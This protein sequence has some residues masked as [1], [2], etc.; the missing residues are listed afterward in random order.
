MLNIG[1][2]NKSPDIFN[3]AISKWKRLL[4]AYIYLQSD[5]PVPVNS[6]WC[7]KPAS[8]RWNNPMS[9]IDGLSQ[10]SCRDFE[11]TAYGVAAL[12]N[13]AETASIQGID[14]YN[15]KETKAAERLQK[16][17][18]LHAKYQNNDSGLPQLCKGY[19]GIKLNTI[20]TF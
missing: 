17:M 16:T 12:I 5:G 6:P 11:H 20:G 18:E 13:V 10:E 3:D 9:F 19:E 1:I 8:Q 14:L 15:D 4:P 7:S 2:F